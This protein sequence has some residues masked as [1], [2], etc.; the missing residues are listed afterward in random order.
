VDLYVFDPYHHFA[1]FEPILDRRIKQGP[2]R[3]GLKN[4]ASFKRRQ[5]AWA[6]FPFGQLWATSSGPKKSLC[7]L[8]HRQNLNRPRRYLF[9]CH[10]SH[11]SAR[12][13]SAQK[14]VPIRAIHAIRG[15]KMFVAIKP[16]RP[17]NVKNRQSHFLLRL[18]FNL[19]QLL[20]GFLFLL[21]RVAL[22]SPKTQTLSQLRM[23]P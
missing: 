8:G 6:P 2:T 19:N 13:K 3:T 7:V 20:L 23:L 4:R 12:R 1:N 16:R 11:E 5:T 17:S 22:E 21:G 15:T 14:F 9:F 18:P 10:E